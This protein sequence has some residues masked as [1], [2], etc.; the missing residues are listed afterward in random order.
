MERI[1][2][3]LESATLL[4]WGAQAASLLV[5]EACRGLPRPHDVFSLPIPKRTQMFPASCRKL[6]A[7]SP[8]SPDV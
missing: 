8:R 2:P 7:G 1:R 6:R 3:V 4:I 5:A